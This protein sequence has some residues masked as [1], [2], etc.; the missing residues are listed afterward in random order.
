[1]RSPQMLLEGLKEMLRDGLMD[2]NA[3]SVKFIGLCRYIAGEPVQ[4][5]I[6]N[7][8]LNDVVEIIDLLPRQDALRHMQQAHVLLLLANGQEDQIPGKTYEY[9]GAGSHILAVTEEKGATGQLVKTIEGS[10]IVEP[11]DMQAMKQ[12]LKKWYDEFSSKANQI[13]P[14][15]FVDSA[16]T[17]QYEWSSLGEQFDQM[18]QQP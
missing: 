17:K 1:M 3:V 8:G 11:G 9:L 5:W 2:K 7:L 6:E 18:L 10:A 13:K 12:I 4:R 14:L 15:P 16:M